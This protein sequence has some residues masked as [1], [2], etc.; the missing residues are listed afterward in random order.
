M[1][2]YLGERTDHR[3]GYIC[4]L[5]LIRRKFR[6]RNCKRCNAG[7]HREEEEEEEYLGR[8]LEVV[9]SGRD[10]KTTTLV[11]EDMIFSSKKNIYICISVCV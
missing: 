8:R 6:C 4:Q 7:I 1:E 10:R 3:V 11:D 5:L 9:A 2:E